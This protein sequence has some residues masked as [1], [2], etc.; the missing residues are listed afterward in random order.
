MEA[1]RGLLRSQF[2]L[3]KWSEAVANAKDLLAEKA[4][5]TDD[6][7]LANLAIAKSAQLGGDCETAITNY[8]SVATLCKAAYG[9]EARYEIANC[10]YTQN[11]LNDA[12]KAAFDVIKKSGSYEEWVTKAYILLG[13]VYYKEKDYFNAKATYK[14]VVDNAKIESLRQEAEKKLKDVTA[15]EASGSKVSE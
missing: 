3:K 14:S 6:K 1:M 12:E 2:Q 5:G 13:D 9:A 11:K 7:V 8:R 10:F 15:E 4:A